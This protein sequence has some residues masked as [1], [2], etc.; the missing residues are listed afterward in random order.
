MARHSQ[1]CSPSKRPKLLLEFAVAAELRGAHGGAN[2]ADG[3]QEILHVHREGLQ[4][5]LVPQGLDLHWAL[6]GHHPAHGHHAGVAAHLVHIGPAVPVGYVSQVHAVDVRTEGNLWRWRAAVGGLMGGHRCW[7]GPH[8]GDSCTALNSS[9]LE[10]CTCCVESDRYAIIPPALSDSM[11]EAG[12]CPA[13]WDL[14]IWQ[15]DER[16]GACFLVCMWALLYLPH[17]IGVTSSEGTST[18]GRGSAAVLEAKRGRLV[19]V[20]AL[21]TAG[22]GNRQTHYQRVQ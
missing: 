7:A 12:A 14:W 13:L 4:Q 2:V 9:V 16:G 11:V 5:P 1:S 3:V 21:G 6:A 18:R 15:A 17:S 22:G 20:R 19:S 10:T 8:R